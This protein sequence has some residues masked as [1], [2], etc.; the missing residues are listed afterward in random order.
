[1]Y[2]A[3]WVHRAKD[4]IASLSTFLAGSVLGNLVWASLTVQFRLKFPTGCLHGLEHVGQIKRQPHLYVSEAVCRIFG[5]VRRIFGG[6]RPGRGV[7]IGYLGVGSGRRCSRLFSSTITHSLRMRM[8]TALVPLDVCN[9]R[10]GRS[11]GSLVYMNTRSQSLHYYLIH[12]C[13]ESRKIQKII[14]LCP[15]QRK[16]KGSKITKKNDSK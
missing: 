8:R 1:M 7:Y 16:K 11:L 12:S 13:L 2:D 9:I 14:V 4:C 5:R 3:H 6:G 10:Q 15:S